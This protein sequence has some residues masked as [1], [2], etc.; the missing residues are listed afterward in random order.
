MINYDCVTH[1]MLDRSIIVAKRWKIK[2]YEALELVVN[3]E[4]QQRKVSRRHSI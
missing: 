2:F 3:V 4:K 1:E